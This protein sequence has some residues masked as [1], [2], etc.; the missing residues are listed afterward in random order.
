[1]VRWAGSGANGLG[2]LGLSIFATGFDIAETYPKHKIPV[3][4]FVGP[5]AVDMKKGTMVCINAVLQP[6]WRFDNGPMFVTKMN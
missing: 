5:D 2:Q 1:M 4:G 3:G 6:G